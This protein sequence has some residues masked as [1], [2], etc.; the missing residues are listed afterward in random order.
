MRIAFLYAAKPRER[1][2]A[3][4]FLRGCR[5][6]GHDT[7]EVPLTPE[8]TVGDYD[9]AVMFGVKSRDRWNAH[10]RA[11][12]AC[13]LLDKGYQRNRVA[14]SSLN[15]YWRVSINSHSPTR[16]LG[17]LECPSDRYRAL[18]WHCA[19]WRESGE[20]IVIAGSSA[21][22]HAFHDL[23]EPNDYAR[24]IVK[25]IRST[26]SERPIVYRP[27]PSWPDAK[28]VKHAS[29][30]V[31]PESL[32]QAMAGAHAV[33]TYG[34]N[35]CFEAVCAGVPCVVLGDAVAKP[36]SSTTFEDIESP[37]LADDSERHRWLANLAYWQWTTAELA[38]GEAWNFLGGMV[39]H[40]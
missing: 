29:F 4:A 28:P 15:E 20:Q 25:G 38:G 1:L 2:L 19:P 40:A 5:E 23:P 22:F 27:K 24:Q 11:G 26:G 17:S 13:L 6:H 34:S 37:R 35:A 10:R 7:L 8:I 16:F 30:S 3:D 31:Y 9:V 36:L 12:V 21:K 18:D 32:A 39:H 14:G 33:V